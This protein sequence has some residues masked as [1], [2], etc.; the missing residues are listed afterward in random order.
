MAIDKS[1]TPPWMRVVLVVLAVA[2]VF[3]VASI[4]MLSLLEGSSTSNKSR[5]TS[6]TLDAAARNWASGA[7]TNEAALRDDPK[8]Y[9][10]LVA[11]ANLYHDWAGEVLQSSQDDQVLM[12]SAVPMWMAAIQYYRRALDLKPGDPAVNT[13]LSVSLFYSGDTTAAIQTAVKVTKS[14][15]KFSPAFLNLG[16]FYEATGN[17]SQSITALKQYLKLEP[18][19]QYAQQAQESIARQQAALGQPTSAQPG[20][21]QPPGGTQQGGAQPGGAQPGGAQPGGAQPGAKQP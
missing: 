3:G 6:S 11:Q 4:P 2:L 9:D 7:M 5:D 21:A 14:D 12:A 18:S 8:N 19:G 20:A 15:P 13:D 17:R 1:R 10:L 16:V